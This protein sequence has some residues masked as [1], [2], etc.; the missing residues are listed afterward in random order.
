MDFMTLILGTGFGLFCVK[1]AF[2]SGNQALGG[3]ENQS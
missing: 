2:I 1:P 3:F